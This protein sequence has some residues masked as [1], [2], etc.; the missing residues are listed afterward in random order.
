MFVALGSWKS[1]ALRGAAAVLFGILTLIWPAISLLVL[2]L[3]FGAYALVDG[4]SVLVA[5]AAK[6]PNTKPSRGLLFLQAGL[7]ILT[8]IITFIWPNITALALLYLIAAWALITGVLQVAA[9][10]RLR[11][12]ISNEWMLG[13]AG[14]LSIVFAIVLIIMPGTGALAI[15]WLI[16]AYA[17]LAGILLLALAFRIRQMLAPLRTA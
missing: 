12:E 6:D 5:T 2:V 1:L 14:V 17:L 16:G 4:A 10:I 15:T 8:G 13:F 9:A 7:G 3:L 11:Q